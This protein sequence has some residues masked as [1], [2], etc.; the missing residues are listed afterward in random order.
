MYMHVGND[1]V[2][3]D[4]E[5]IGIFDIDNCTVDKKTREF[6]LYCQKNG[7]IVDAADDL[8]K[9][10]VLSQRNVYISGT[11]P[12]TLIKR[13]CKS[14]RVTKTFRRTHDDKSRKGHYSKD[15]V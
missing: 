6:L 2:V 7:R 15:A 10:F 12:A 14:N 5:I 1:R 11:S 4:C 13:A 3:R 8:P 9:A